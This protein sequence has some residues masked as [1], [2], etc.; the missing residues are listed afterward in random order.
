MIDRQLMR[1]GGT[2]TPSQSVELDAPNIEVVEA[3]GEYAQIVAGPLLPGFGT[4]LGNSLRRVLLSSLPGA[5]VVSVRI[6]GVQH[7]FSTISQVKE[8]S[9]EFLLNVKELRLRAHSDRPATLILDVSGR[10]GE[11]LAGD[12]QAP[13][14][15]DIVNPNLHLATL[16]SAEGR[17][18]VEFNVERGR[19]YQPAGPTDGLAIGVIPIDAIYTPVRKVNYKVEH[20]RVGQETG[21]DKLVLEVWTDGSITGVE[22]ISASSD[23]LIEQLRFFSNMGKPAMPVVERGLGAGIVLTTDIYNMPIEDLGLSM[24]AYNCLRRSGLM[25]V[26]QV[27]EKSE[28][29]LLNLRNF[30]RKSYDEL[31]EK[32]EEFGL[33]P[34]AA[35][36]MME[37]APLDEGEEMPPA[38]EAG[39]LKV[40]GSKEAGQEP[41][42][43]APTARAADAPEAE[44]G[45]EELTDW[46]RDLLSLKDEV[47]EGK[48]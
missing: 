30:G 9:I 12:I 26:G 23:I 2:E 36:E 43:A 10:E 38:M 33:L 27:M 21:F 1:V 5:A 40:G 4:T 25:T 22:A 46:Q 41:A 48:D 47:G 14:H 3:A 8:D 20:T 32:L 16:N 34:R 11:V 31:R 13:E 29:D 42:K 28:D 19:G 45:A 24:R 17:L 37:A 15:Y 35:Q 39:E 6:E 44:E 7:E 18:F